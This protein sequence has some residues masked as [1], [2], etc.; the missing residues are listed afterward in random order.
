M[1]SFFTRS[2]ARFAA[3]PDASPKNF[4]SRPPDFLK[5]VQR[6]TALESRLQAVIKSFRTDFI[7]YL[8]LYFILLKSMV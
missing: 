3:A 1:Q 2:W 6:E 7:L 5:F 4:F 8:I